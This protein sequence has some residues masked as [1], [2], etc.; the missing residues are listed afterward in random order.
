MLA[1]NNNIFIILIPFYRKDLLKRRVRHKIMKH[2]LIFIVLVALLI[3][4]G[5]KKTEP[6]PSYKP[7]PQEIQIPDVNA[8]K[9]TDI[10]QYQK[11]STYVYVIDSRIQDQTTITK[12]AY[13]VSEVASGNSKLWLI[14]SEST[15]PQ[16]LIASN[17]WVDSITHKCTTKETYLYAN[18][19]S[20]IQPGP[21]PASG[22]YASTKTLK[23]TLNGTE[24][25][26]TAFGQLMAKKYSLNG[27]DYWVAYGYPL[28]LKITHNNGAVQMQLIEFK[29]VLK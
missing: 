15:T 26:K 17:M 29:E 8:E 5:C 19:R 2:A 22:P 13:K 14:Y 11:V 18:N 20:T 12:Y 10:F 21:C 16:G 3:L 6:L 28:P 1:F 24:S 7:P 23:L 27:V 9:L 4:T 25:I